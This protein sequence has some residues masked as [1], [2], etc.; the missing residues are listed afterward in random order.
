PPTTRDKRSNHDVTEGPLKRYS[1]QTQRV[2]DHRDGTQAHCGPGDHWAEKPAEK[3]IK[4]SRS[5]WNAQRVVNKSEEKIL[6]DVSHHRATE[7]NRFLDPT[8]I[9][10]HQSDSGAF[11]RDI[12]PV[13]IA[14]PTSA[15]TSAG[16]SLM[17]SPAMATIRPCSRNSRTRSFFRCGST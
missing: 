4:C 5:D 14:M 11:H 17:P 10:F 12:L 13:P 15:A 2:C 1:T 9:A 16:A 7:P 6:A 8:Q 3:R